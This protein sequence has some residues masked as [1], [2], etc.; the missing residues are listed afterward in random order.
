M[1]TKYWITVAPK[2]HVE[3]GVKE[4]FAQVCHGKVSPLNRMNPG[5]WVIYYSPKIK[6]QKTE[7]CQKFTAIG[8][9][10]GPV[11][12]YTVVDGFTPFRIPV[13]FVSCTEA[14]IAPLIGTLSF[15]KNKAKWGGPFRF[16][17]INVNYDDFR[18]IAKSMRV[19]V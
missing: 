7:K 16:G 12:Q 10:T 17:I 13:T 1:N 11:Y 14:P 5:D 18:Q 2:D 3:I 9:V 19:K 15:I 8:R 6:F 4:G